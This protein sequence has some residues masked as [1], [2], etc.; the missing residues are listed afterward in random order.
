[1]VC[2]IWCCRARVIGSSSESDNDAA[3]TDTSSRAAGG[4]SPVRSGSPVRRKS[5]L[6]IKDLKVH[7]FTGSHTY[8]DFRPDLE[9]EDGRGVFLDGMWRAITR[10]PTAA[11][12]RLNTSG[13]THD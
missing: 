11:A 12:F 8:F 7:S 3:G 6:S 10:H 2:T 5:G 1:M 9:F 4:H 13:V